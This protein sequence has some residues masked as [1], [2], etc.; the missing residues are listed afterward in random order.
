MYKLLMGL[1]EG[2]LPFLTQRRHHNKKRI[3]GKLW[4]RKNFTV[5]NGLMGEGHWKGLTY[6]T[7]Q[8]IMVTER[9]GW[10]F[11]WRTQVLFLGP[12]M[13]L[14]WTSGDVYPGFETQGGS[15]ACVLSRLCDPEIHFWC[16]TCWL[17][18]GQRGSLFDPHTCRSCVHKH[19]WI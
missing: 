14:F 11:F 5:I 18:R 10:Y 12:L 1:C 8:D 3:V 7:W 17:F 4:E 13:P 19:W 6:F 16:N 15:L 2:W 9:I